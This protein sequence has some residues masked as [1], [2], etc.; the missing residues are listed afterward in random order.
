MQVPNHTNT[1]DSRVTAVRNDGT[2]P[3]ANVTGGTPM[4]SSTPVTTSELPLAVPTDV[5]RGFPI[6]VGLQN[7]TVADSSW[8]ELHGYIRVRFNI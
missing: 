8:A 6:E 1:D 5:V 7:E 4:P 2:G 3:P